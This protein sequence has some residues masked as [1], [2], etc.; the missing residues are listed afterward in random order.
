MMSTEDVFKKVLK[1]DKIRELLRRQNQKPTTD[2]RKNV[3]DA[4][5][6]NRKLLLDA[7]KRG[8]KQVTLASPVDGHIEAFKLI[9]DSLDNQLAFM[10]PVDRRKFTPCGW[11]RVEWLEKS[12]TNDEAEAE[13]NT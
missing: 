3:W 10:R 8:N 5:I 9:Y 6:E 13:A 4:P 11:Y 12:I 2:Y 1:A 7:I